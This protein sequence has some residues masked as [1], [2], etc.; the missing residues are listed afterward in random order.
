ME[1]YTLKLVI[2]ILVCLLIS[3]TVII[4]YI[5]LKQKTRA[6]LHKN[7]KYK[8]GTGTITM[9]TASFIY[10]FITDHDQANWNSRRCI[11]FIERQN[12]IHGVEFA[13]CINYIQSKK[14]GYNDFNEYTYY[15]E[16]WLK[17]EKT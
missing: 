3:E 17:P 7:N 11:E 6:K 15:V 14:I 9:F 8:P 4:I 13:R 1:T 16:Y 12:G 10:D 5:I 2:F